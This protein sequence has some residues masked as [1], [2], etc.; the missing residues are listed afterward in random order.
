MNN[1]GVDLKRTTLLMGPSKTE[2]KKE[3]PS[4]GESKKTEPVKP[5]VKNESPSSS[6]KSKN[7]K[8]APK[9]QGT[10]DFEGN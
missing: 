6:V 5:A 1:G 10:F 9:D 8:V 2:I 3:S 7:E 4:T